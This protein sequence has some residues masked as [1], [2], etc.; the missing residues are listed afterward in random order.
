MTDATIYS[1]NDTAG[2]GLPTGSPVARLFSVLYACL[3]TGY[4]AKP[5][6]GWTLLDNS[7][8]AGFTMRSPDGVYVCIAA[9]PGT[10]N[11]QVYLA[12]SVVSPYQY[13]PVGVNVRSQNYSP[14]FVPT[15]A[16]RHTVNVG[17][18]SNSYSADWWSVICRGSQVLVFFQNSNLNIGMNSASPR[19]GPFFIGNLKMKSPGAP[20][21]GV[22][23]FIFLGGN[24]T[25]S[26]T[27]A[28]SNVYPFSTACTHLRNL[29]DGTVETGLLA[30]VSGDPWEY[31]SAARVA[32]PPRL[33]DLALVQADVRLSGV[34]S[35][36]YLPGVFASVPGSN[37]LAADLLSALG[38]DASFLALDEPLDIGGE[39][40]YAMP[41][42][43]GLLFVSP[44]EAY[45]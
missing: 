31:Y 10:Y 43:N 21:S 39:S 44:N 41:G 40:F 30:T 1:S 28:G 20:S 26:N 34:G 37:Y 12:E 5:G 23:N 17:G 45:W 19:A 29:L 27:A 32:A 11:A 15:E 13:P 42:P 38:R 35:I 4:G 25:V 14:D 2:P 9:A 16:L 33:P 7:G 8:D 24:I 36:A 18:V 6:Q 3:V 22:Q